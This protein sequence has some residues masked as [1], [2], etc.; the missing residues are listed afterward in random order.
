MTLPIRLALVRHG[1]S[2]SNLAKSMFEHGEVLA[3]ENELMK[4]HTSER[5]LTPLGIRQA[6]AAGEWL[7]ANHLT[8]GLQRF[9]VS[10]YIRA[11]ETAANLGFGDD[12]KIDARLMERNWG[13]FD[14]MPYGERV[15]QFKEQLEL[16]KEHA[17]FWRPTNGET[18]QDVFSRL[19]DMN[20]TLHRDCA[21]HHVVAVT[22]GE[23]MWVWRT[24][25]ERWMPQQLREAM[26]N[27]N[28]QT[29]IRNCRIIEYTR[30][31]GDGT[32][33]ERFV[34]MRFVNPENPY[35]ALTNLGWNTI[36]RKKWSS[37]DLQQYVSG[38]R[39]FI[40]ITESA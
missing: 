1:E 21:Q 2:E 30:E 20:S 26:L 11:M 17:F 13:E 7:Q 8:T 4:V 25:L 29:R 15:A 32:C 33:A 39:S 14:Q 5:R 3:T 18:F 27:Q 36:P 19:R 10:P 12:W 38:F 40:P 28:E 35:D 9:Y 16:R 23:T 22:H 34:R 37:S 31:V 6:K 24:V